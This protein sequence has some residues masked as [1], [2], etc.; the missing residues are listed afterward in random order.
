M[1]TPNGLQGHRTRQHPLGLIGVPDAVGGKR[2]SGS[3]EG[4]RLAALVRGLTWISLLLGIGAGAL[5]GQYCDHQA[6]GRQAAGLVRRIVGGEDVGT[7]GLE[8]PQHVNHAVNE[9]TGDLIGVELKPGLF[10][11]GTVRYGDGR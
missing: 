4:V 1:P 10:P 8:Y 3:R 2:T 7:L 11:V 6:I 5:T 9:R